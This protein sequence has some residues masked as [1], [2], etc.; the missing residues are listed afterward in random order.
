MAASPALRCAPLARWISRERALLFRITH[1]ENMPWLLRHGLHP[2]TGRRD[3]TFVSIGDAE[4]IGKRM[5]K[6]VPLAPRGTLANY[7]SFYF[8][9]R[10]PMLYRIQNGFN[11]AQ[12]KREEIV[13]IVTSIHKL[14]E[15]GMTFLHTD[16]HAYHRKARFFQNA[17]GLVNIDWDLLRQGRIGFDSADSS[18]RIQAEALVYKH[19]S[20][21]A[22]LGFA[23]AT[24]P[25]R[26]YIESVAQSNG[27]NFPVKVRREWYFR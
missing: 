25:V 8:T 26:R 5:R 15:A 14:R 10:S 18:K 21:D 13:F 22:L 12:R 3:P 4:L 24:D 6:P 11:V 27:V 2:A 23:A 1:V 16:S 19:V 7:V 17:S 20:V 9:P